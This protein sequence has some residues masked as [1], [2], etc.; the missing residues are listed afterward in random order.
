MF[1]IT[2]LVCPKSSALFEKIW[3]YLAQ[4][5]LNLLQIISLTSASCKSTF[6]CTEMSAAEQINLPSSDCDG[7][8]D[9][10]DVTFNI[11]SSVAVAVVYIYL[12]QITLKFHFCL[13]R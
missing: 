10:P 6:Q 4:R 2:R 13:E 7:F 12:A 8:S 11:K 9:S 1:M 3:E 5:L